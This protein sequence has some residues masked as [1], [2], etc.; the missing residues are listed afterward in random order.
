[1]T[2]IILGFMLI[3]VQQLIKGTPIGYSYIG[4]VMIAL[5]A[6]AALATMVEK[7]NEKDR[8]NNR[9]R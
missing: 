2:G 1:M 3:M 7:Q 5:G 9:G 8:E 4:L 6:L